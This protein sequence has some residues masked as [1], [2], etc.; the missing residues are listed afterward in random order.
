MTLSSIFSFQKSTCALSA[1]ALTVATMLA[2][3]ATDARAEAPASVGEWV[4]HAEAQL[5][6]TIQYPAFALREGKQGLARI[7]ATVSPD[8]TLKD[9][10]IARSTGD[11][12]LDKAALKAV[13]KLD[14][15]PPLPQAATPRNITLQVGFGIARTPEQEV[16]LA[17]A[18]KEQPET[19]LASAK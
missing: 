1:I 9:V 16:Q 10:S 4:S 3:T 2:T 12:G 6:K 19:A 11:A 18:F 5:D 15:L 7:S 13:Q 17:E 8:G 14:K